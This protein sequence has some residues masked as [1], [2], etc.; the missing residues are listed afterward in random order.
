MLSTSENEM[1]RTCVKLSGKQL[2][3]A[4]E[5]WLKHNGH[6]SGE[7]KLVDIGL[8]SDVNG[9]KDYAVDLCDDDES[10]IVAEFER[11]K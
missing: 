2:A 8:H 6:I 3:E 10:G 1:L 5:Q 7:L 4:V 9:E 11:P